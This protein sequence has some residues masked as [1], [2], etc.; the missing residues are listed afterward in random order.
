MAVHLAAGRRNTSMDAKLQNDATLSLLDDPRQIDA[1]CRLRARVW[2]V[3]NGIAQNAFPDGVWRDPYDDLA[4]HWM[5]HDEGRLIAAARLLLHERIEDAIEAFQYA[6]YA[7]RWQGLIAAPDHVVVCPSAQ[8][9]GIAS[10][11]LAAQEEMARADGATFAIRQASPRMVQLLVRRGWRLHGPA[12]P[13]ARF[14][15]VSFTVASKELLSAE[16]KR[17]MERA[18]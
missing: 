3:A 6:R 1:I 11:L 12:L 7:I 17:A 5:V 13:D 15:G 2:R 9:R 18:A 10:L 8:G 16:A 14:P 4:V